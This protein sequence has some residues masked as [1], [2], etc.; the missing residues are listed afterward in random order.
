MWDQTEREE[1]LWTE[2]AFNVKGLSDNKP[3]E[4]EAVVVLDPKERDK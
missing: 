1:N 2:S 3:L 4:E